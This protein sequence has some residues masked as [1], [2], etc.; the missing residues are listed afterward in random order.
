MAT[1]LTGPLVRDGAS[2]A[3]VVAFEDEADRS[4]PASL[5]VAEH[6]EQAGVEV[7]DVMVVRDGRRYSPRCDRDCCPS[8]GIAL[9]DP[10][11]VVGVA[12]YVARGRAP[13]TS[14]S[15]VDALVQGDPAASAGVA[16]A[17]E[18]REGMPRRRLRRRSASAW[19][20]VLRPPRT[21]GSARDGGGRDGL[22][23][24]RGVQHLSPT[25]VAD[26]AL[27]LR[28]IA[29]R[30]AVIAWLAPGV[31]PL[32][33]LQRSAVRLLEST[34]PSWGGMGFDGEP[35]EGSDE[36]LRLLVALCRSLPDET[37][38][39]TAAVCAVVAHVAWAGG[40]GTVAR[41]AIERAQHLAPDYRLAALLAKLI[42]N[43]IR[44]PVISATEEVTQDGDGRLDRAG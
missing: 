12:E 31:L 21:D 8:E 35:G 26:L 42:D 7:L 37:A 23:R 10:A 30:D 17:I 33:D 3:I 20:E 34:M 2:A 40:D 22:S 4:V 41:A 11:D 16:A 15:A 44:F 27:G 18:A 1:W 13:L 24:G 28:D 29:W 25:V 14:R 19:A 32:A 9:P 36:V 38:Q 43:G 6:L 39:D 5:A